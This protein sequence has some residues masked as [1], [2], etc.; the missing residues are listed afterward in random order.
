MKNKDHTILLV[1]LA[2]AIFLG[3]LWQF[4]PLKD[5]G[6]R[7]KLIPLQGIG[8]KGKDVSLNSDESN[9]FKDINIIKRIY[10][11]GEDKFLITIIDATNNRHVV[12]DPYY[13]FKGGGWLIVKEEKYTLNKG[14]A[15]LL[16]IRKNGSEREAMFWFSDGKKQHFSPLKYWLQATLRRVTLGLSGPEPVYIV[17]QPLKSG[18]IDWVDFIDRFSSL[19]II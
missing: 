13:C 18:S 8:Y 10:L 5:A 15:N 6:N 12:H 3:L 4:L 19:F 1:G 7:M 14:E 11:V 9:F 17:V 2:V 16:V